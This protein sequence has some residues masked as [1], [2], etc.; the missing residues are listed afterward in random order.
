MC[1]T[2]RCGE[3][4]SSVGLFGLLRSLKLLRCKDTLAKVDA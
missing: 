2:H 3:L 1:G 4:T